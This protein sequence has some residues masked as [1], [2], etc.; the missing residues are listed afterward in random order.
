MSSHPGHKVAA[1]AVTEGKVELA[2]ADHEFPIGFPTAE[3][4]PESG[5]ELV[6]IFVH[7]VDLVKAEKTYFPFHAQMSTQ[8]EIQETAETQ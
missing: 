1:V 7:I 8:I 5:T 4:P 6:V 3:T 2:V